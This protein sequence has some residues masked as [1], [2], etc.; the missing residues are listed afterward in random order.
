MSVTSYTERPATKADETD[1]LSVPWSPSRPK[2]RGVSARAVSAVTILAVL[3]AW[4]LST[5][6]QLVPAVFLP[7][8]AAVWA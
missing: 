8:P 2:R 7:S 4:A 3:A 1:S 6:L 5:R